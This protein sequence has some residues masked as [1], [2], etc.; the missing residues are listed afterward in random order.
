MGLF[1]VFGGKKKPNGYDGDGCV[2][3]IPPL[4]PPRVPIDDG[5]GG[6]TLVRFDPCG[7]FFSCPCVFSSLSPHP[8]F[9][10]LLLFARNP[11]HHLLPRASATTSPAGPPW[12]NAPRASSTG[13]SWAQPGGAPSAPPGSA[14]GRSPDQRQGT[15]SLSQQARSGARKTRPGRSGRPMRTIARPGRPAR[16]PGGSAATPRRGRYA[17]GTPAA[18]APR[19]S[20]G[21]GSSG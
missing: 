3:I 20:A 12:R 19:C 6:L 8:L 16:P 7:C 10:F 13:A 11:P 1:G 15:R 21:G 5:E 17:R 2:A 4:S 9:L 18:F 14:S